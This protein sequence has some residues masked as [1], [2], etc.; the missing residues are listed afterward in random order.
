MSCTNPNCN[1]GCG[2]NNC[3]PP[4][5]PPIPP[6]PPICVGTKCEEIY[7]AACVNY[8][9]P[10]L[11]CFN[12]TTDTNLNSVIQ[13]IATNICNCCVNSKCTSP[14]EIFFERFKTIWDT[15]HVADPSLSFY[16]VFNAYLYQGIIVK[17]CQY[18]CP[19]DFI[20]SLSI[21]SDR[22]TF[23]TEILTALASTGSNV[24]IPCKNCWTK[25]N[26]SATEL[27]TLFDP[28][29]NGTHS[30]AFTVDDICEW[31]GFNNI[32]GLYDFNITIK[33]LFT[34][35]QI[36]DIMKSISINS[37]QIVCD[38]NSGNI[39]IGSYD[40]VQDYVYNQMNIPYGA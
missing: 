40:L 2:C 3:C 6:V 29:L 10:A 23:L 35:S 18:C 26:V 21:G 38:L 7:D 4:I 15:V 11:P 32:S 30:P 16:D 28:T 14:F 34:T 36:T 9:G 25:F 17:K 20:Y 22:C 33:K 8:T 37:L 24:E 19:D 39:I 31:G 1:Q 27:L 13:T 5:T 12:I